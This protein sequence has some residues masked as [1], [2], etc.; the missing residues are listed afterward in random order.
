M[1]A[2][3]APPAPNPSRVRRIHPG[4]RR[5]LPAG[6]M[7]I[8]LL[9][10]APVVSAHGTG[11]PPAP[12]AAGLVLGWSFDPTIWL[13]LALAAAAYLWAVR[14]VNAAHP[15]KPVPRDRPVFFLLG[16]AAIAIA[17]Q[18]GIERYDTTLFSLHMVQHVILIFLAAP[19]IV[20]SAPITL[21]LRVATPRVRQRWVLP[22]LD[23]R[24]VRVI[25]HP[26]VAWVLFTAV[27]WGT[28]F[29]PLFDA[30]LEN[31]WLHDLEHVL[32]LVSSMLFWMPVVGRDPSPW[33]LGYPA[34]ILYLFVQ[35]PLNS[36]LGVAI[37][38]SGTILYPHYATTGR[39]WGPSPLQDQQA[40]GAIMWGLGDAGFLLAL[41]LLIAAWMRFDE[42][43]T[44]RRESAEDARLAGRAAAAEAVS[45]AGAAGA[46]NPRLPSP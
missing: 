23:S 32:Y 4:P 44:R 25:G 16:L 39:L 38:Y 14:R 17:L 26:L 8:A 31:V 11:V 36:F 2:P 6:A 29:S 30:T 21:V 43:A 15:A 37:L 24:V 35:M 34:R 7:L 33:R 28:H 46:G 45:A 41:L 1:T 19:A 10:G 42:A 27:M 9:A 3:D 12:D 22:V 13:P 40:A 5:W 18:S 20:L